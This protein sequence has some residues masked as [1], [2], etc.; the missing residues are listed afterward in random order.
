MAIFFISFNLWTSMFFFRFII[1]SF[2]VFIVILNYHY[3]GP[4]T[5]LI[6]IGCS[7]S[8]LSYICQIRNAFQVNC[9][10]HLPRRDI[11]RCFLIF[12]YIDYC[13]LSF[14]FYTLIKCNVNFFNYFS[15]IILLNFVSFDHRDTMWKR[16]K[17]INTRYI[18]GLLLD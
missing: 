11:L 16:I 6:F 17:K 9:L 3:L 2:I 18:I 14:L 12:L 5:W 13:A 8:N 7:R 15:K 10:L 1:F 4:Y